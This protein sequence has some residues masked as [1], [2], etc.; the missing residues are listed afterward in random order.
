MSKYTILE[1]HDSVKV[2][3]FITKVRFLRSERKDRTIECVMS[4]TSVT[5]Q[6]SELSRKD[7]TGAKDYHR[8]ESKGRGV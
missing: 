1:L 4:L 5:K 3:W 2:F 8:T 7:T 6:R